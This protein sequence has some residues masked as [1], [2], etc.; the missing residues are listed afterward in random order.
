MF[1]GLRVHTPHEALSCLHNAACILCASRIGYV[2]HRPMLIA[3][4]AQTTTIMYGKMQVMELS[5][6][7]ALWYTLELK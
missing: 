7:Q 1:L 6:Q 3:D 4:S 5:L 2:Y